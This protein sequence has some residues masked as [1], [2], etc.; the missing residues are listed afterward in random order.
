MSP[1]PLGSPCRRG[2]GTRMRCPSRV[3]KL[4]RPLMPTRRG[5]RDEP[6]PLAG[7]VLVHRPGQHR[8]PDAEHGHEHARDDHREGSPGRPRLR[9][10]R[11]RCRRNGC[12]DRRRR[13]D[14]GAH[15]VVL[16]ARDAIAE[17]CIRLTEAGEPVRRVGVVG[18]VGVRALRLL[19]ERPRDRVGVGTR[20]DA[21]QRVVVDRGPV[22]DAR[23]RHAPTLPMRRSGGQSSFSATAL[24]VTCIAG[25]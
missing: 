23:A 25:S 4:T 11:R 19:T 7:V 13:P 18:G 2:S 6:R 15:A 12:G 17:H 5:D 24:G 8:R 21:E 1:L 20:I 9:C 3:T 16:A 14:L 10:P 22:A